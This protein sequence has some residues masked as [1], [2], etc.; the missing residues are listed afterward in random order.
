MRT[1]SRNPSFSKHQEA[2]EETV[3]VMGEYKSGGMTIFVILSSNLADGYVV[4]NQ[5]IRLEEKP[6]KIR[7][8][9]HT[10]RTTGSMIES[11]EI[12]G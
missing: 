2:V 5:P 10:G 3:A 12:F 9:C 4:S 1:C 11:S 8:P 6:Q 7:L